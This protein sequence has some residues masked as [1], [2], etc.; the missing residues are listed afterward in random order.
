M[1]AVPG[2]G[3]G[4]GLVPGV[5]LDVQ[6]DLEQVGVL[7]LDVAGIEVV[8]GRT[9]GQRGR[10]E[11]F[12]SDEQQRP[13]RASS[14]ASM[15]LAWTYLANLT[16]VAFLGTKPVWNWI[17]NIFMEAIWN[18]IKFTSSVKVILLAVSIYTQS[19]KII[20][21]HIRKRKYDV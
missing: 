9:S 1:E 10:V 16:V 17:W 12:K 6:I 4:A 8:P 5:N 11:R 18:A 20:Y 7:L 2:G 21:T 15:N 19:A 13:R 3:L 14:G